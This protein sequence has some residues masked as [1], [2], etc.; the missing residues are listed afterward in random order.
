MQGIRYLSFV[1]LVAITTGCSSRPVPPEPSGPLLKI[2][3]NQ[4]HEKYQGDN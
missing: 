4:P 2:N 1:L 3:H